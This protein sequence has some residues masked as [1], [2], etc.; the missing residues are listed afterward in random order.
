MSLL[1]PPFI[2]P[3][4]RGVGVGARRTSG[5]QRPRFLAGP[6]AKLFFMG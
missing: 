6:A 1:L 3:S 4:V 5:A 2:A